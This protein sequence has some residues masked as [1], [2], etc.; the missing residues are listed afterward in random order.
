MYVRTNS[1]LDVILDHPVVTQDINMERIINIGSG[2]PV[3]QES[4][5]DTYYKLLESS[6]TFH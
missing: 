6:K 1:H 5:L 2:A 4:S 3:V